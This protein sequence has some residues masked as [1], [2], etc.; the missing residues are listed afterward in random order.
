VGGTTAVVGAGG[1]AQLA[2]IMLTIISKLIRN[3]RRFLSIIFAS[4]LFS[5]RLVETMNG[6]IPGRNRSL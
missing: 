5:L 6:S 1:V 3:Q 2:I 4:F